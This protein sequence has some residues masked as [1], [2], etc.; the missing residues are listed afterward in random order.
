MAPSSLW[1]LPKLVCDSLGTLRIVPPWATQIYHNEVDTAHFIDMLDIILEDLHATRRQFAESICESVNLEQSGHASGS[2]QVR[3]T[4]SSI[5]KS[6]N[7]CSRSK[8]SFH[9][10]GPHDDAQWSS[11][12]DGDCDSG[13]DLLQLHRWR[14]ITQPEY[15]LRRVRKLLR[16]GPV[17]L[18]ETKWNGTQEESI[19]Q[20]IPGVQISSSNATPNENGELILLPAGWVAARNWFG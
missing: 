1:L 18:Q 4:P 20:N 11:T 13:K 7:D 8:K 16:Q 6:S 10:Q 17:C 3:P 2:E 14:S 5:H 15:K 19:H 9:I 12:R